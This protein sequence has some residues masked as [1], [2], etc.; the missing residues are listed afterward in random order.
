MNKKIVSKKI[1]SRKPDLEF[2]KMYQSSLSERIDVLQNNPTGPFLNL[3]GQLYGETSFAPEFDESNDEI[4]KLVRVLAE[5]NEIRP[6]QTLI[7][8]SLGKMDGCSRFV[9][10]V[11]KALKNLNQRSVIIDANVNSRGFTRLTRKHADGLGLM[12][13]LA[14]EAPVWRSLSRRDESEVFLLER[15]RTR[16]NTT[17]L[18]CEN[19]IN[20]M[21]E[22]FRN[23]FNYI[24]IEVPPLLD[25][26]NLQL[27]ARSGDAIA[28]IENEDAPYSMELADIQNKIE[29]SGVEFWGIFKSSATSNA[30]RTV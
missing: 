11:S 23:L 2:L 20:E 12:D 4:H 26:S 30:L 15:G 5:N 24:I 28:L 7:I 29:E 18:L 8:S 19:S 27:W 1:K 9:F 16:L 22:L 14:G 3:Y 6:Q 10:E 25:A 13:L 17:K 21:T